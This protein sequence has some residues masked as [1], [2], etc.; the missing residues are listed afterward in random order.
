MNEAT[1]SAFMYT[2]PGRTV[3]EDRRELEARV[4]RA[5]E[6]LGVAAPPPVVE[7]THNWPD[8]YQATEVN[9]ILEV[10]QNAGEA[11]TGQRLTVEGGAAMDLYS[12][13][14]YSGGM[15]SVAIGPSHF[16]IPEASHQ[17]N[18]SISIDGEL[19]PFVKIIALTMLTW[20]GWEA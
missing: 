12:M 7:W 19:I 11:V 2:L 8:P 9:P 17:P 16:G 13:G 4:G 14:L 20:C 15:P 5:W 1:V 6:A 18:E 3:Y 10:L